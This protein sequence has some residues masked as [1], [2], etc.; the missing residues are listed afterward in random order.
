MVESLQNGARL[1]CARTQLKVPLMLH[2]QKSSTK[3]YVKKKGI[4]CPTVYRQF[5][6]KTITNAA[7]NDSLKVPLLHKQVLNETHK[8]LKEN[9]QKNSYSKFDKIIL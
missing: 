3:L 9:E 6:F 8:N 5:L 1:K 4:N 2:I 7:C